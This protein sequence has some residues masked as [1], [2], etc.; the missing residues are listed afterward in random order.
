[1]IFLSRDKLFELSGA[2]T[3]ERRGF[4]ERINLALLILAEFAKSPSHHAPALASS[5][6]VAVRDYVATYLDTPLRVP[7]LAAVAGLSPGR[8]A[9]AFRAAT[10]SPPHR[11]V[12]G[13]RVVRALELLR[14]GK[15]DLSEVALAC[16]FSSQQH[17][18]TTLHRVTG[19]TPARVRKTCGVPATLTERSGAAMAG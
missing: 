7:D 19:T 16:G 3:F 2:V 14:A 18:T 8:F 6:L 17:M 15:L 5:A 4:L 13:R 10:G 11:Y 1:L 9:V 12:L